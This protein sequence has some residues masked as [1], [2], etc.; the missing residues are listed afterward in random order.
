[1]EK[2]NGKVS[3]AQKMRNEEELKKVSEKGTTYEEKKQEKKKH[4]RIF[5]TTRFYNTG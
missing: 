2:K 4:V 3:C 5:T 1:M